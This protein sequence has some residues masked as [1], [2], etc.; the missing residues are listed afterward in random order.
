MNPLR[1]RSARVLLRLSLVP[2]LFALLHLLGAQSSLPVFLG[3]YFVAGTSV[4]IFSF[5]GNRWVGT[6]FNPLS[7]QVRS[8][9]RE[10]G[11]LT[12]WRERIGGIINMVAGGVVWPVIFL[13]FPLLLPRVVHMRAGLPRIDVEMLREDARLR[14]RILVDSAVVLAGALTSYLLTLA[15]VGE[16]RVL[17]L[18]Y[19]LFVT[20]TLLAFTIGP[21]SFPDVFRRASG[22]PYANLL[23]VGLACA[24]IVYISFLAL[25][26]GAGA[27]TQDEAARLAA[28]FARGLRPWDLLQPS[29][30]ALDAFLKLNALLF[31]TSIL[32]LAFRWKEF[33]R[34]DRHFEA[35]ANACT[36]LRRFD[37]ALR[38]LGKVRNP[39]QS[40]WVGYI[41]AY[42]GAGQLDAALDAG[43][44]A[45]AVD[46]GELHMVRSDPYALAGAILVEMRHNSPVTRKVARGLVLRW[47][48]DEPDDAR[49]LIVTVLLRGTGQLDD[50]A[51]DEALAAAQARRRLALARA[52][53][54]LLAGNARGA[55]RL[56]RKTGRRPGLAGALRDIIELAVTIREADSVFA[57]ERWFVRALPRFQEL[58]AQLDEDLDRL[59]LFAAVK[60][61][62][63]IGDD[64][65]PELLHPWQGLAE[66]IEHAME[67]R[68]V[69]LIA[70]FTNLQVA[71]K[72]REAFAAR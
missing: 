13:R 43:R 71:E 32:S 25:R 63:V 46:Q 35:L 58:A 41:P 34:E 44:R 8:A 2:A 51:L 61:A 47:V 21:G 1:Y 50:D 70:H 10:V 54:L 12:R 29:G 55:G 45:V 48:A 62:C 3:G 9:V 65:R 59:G 66:Q 38:W 28:D 60:M 64:L 37:E 57:V 56:L 27:P 26:H 24:G 19:A 7:E 36:R 22:H 18:L 42:L 40:T 31:G 52:G 4:Y 6:V 49:F 68:K 11:W 5:I 67:E 23:R 17:F 53:L 15:G 72:E 39:R 16:A 33:Q 20:L 14:P 69:R 30:G